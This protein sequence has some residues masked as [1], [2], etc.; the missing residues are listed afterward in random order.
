MSDYRFSS[1]I[2]KCRKAGLGDKVAST[3]LKKIMYVHYLFIYLATVG[4]DCGIFFLSCC[5]W[6]LVP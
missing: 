1:M 5:M 2:G 4:L 3:P 6:S